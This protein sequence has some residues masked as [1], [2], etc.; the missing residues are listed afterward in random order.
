MRGFRWFAMLLVAA[1]VAI[2]GPAAIQSASFDY[3]VLS[4]SWSPQHCASENA[5]RDRLQCGLGRRYGFVVHGLWPQYQDGGFPE[6]CAGVRNVPDRVVRGVIDIM[7]SEG[8]IR[9][10]WRKHGSC[11][12][13]DVDGYFDRVRTARQSLRLPPE[14][15]EPTQP[16]RRSAEQL[17]RELIQANPRLADNMIIVNCSGQYLSEVRICYDKDLNPRACG[18]RVLP[19]SC[20]EQHF[21]LRPV[22]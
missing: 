14:L 18:R 19:G 7:P 17:R 10:Q 13:L 5:E 3:Y 15:R 21:I 11:S 8:L 12:G 20:R 22:R 6:Q 1:I 9:H 16:L 2:S 4:L